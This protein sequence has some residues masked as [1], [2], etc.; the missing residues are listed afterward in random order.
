MAIIDEHGVVLRNIQEQ[1]Q[2][3]KCDIEELKQAGMG[4]EPV[5]G[6][7]GPAGEQGPV[8]PE[9][10]RGASL[11]GTSAMLPS[12][13][14]YKDGDMFLLNSGALYK[15][16]N[17]RWI[18]QA[19]LRGPQGVQGDPGSQV[20]PNPEGE[21]QDE[22]S[23]VE[24]DGVRYRIVGDPRWGSIGGVLTQ[25]ADLW[26]QL[27]NIREVAEGKS[28]GYL[29][30]INMAAPTTDEDF[31][32][33]HYCRG[34]GARITS[35][36]EF[37]S[38]VGASAYANDLFGEG[39]VNLPDSYI[40]VEKDNRLFVMVYDDE[41]APLKDGDIILTEQTDKADYW[42]WSSEDFFVLET[43][44]V[45]LSGF[46]KIDVDNNFS[47]GQTIPSLTM[48]AGAKINTVGVLNDITIWGSSVE[49]A[50][51]IFPKTNNLYDLGLSAN[52]WKDL[53]LS[54]IA[55]VPR[56]Q[57]P[58]KTAGRTKASYITTDNYD[59]IQAWINGENSITIY[60]GS[61]YVKKKTYVQNILEITSGNTLK[62]GDTTLNEAQLQALLALIA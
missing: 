46:A 44:K 50:K 58:I 23:N 57:F 25:Q 18:Q 20:I 19:T 51:T 55:F 41:Y 14:A 26:G 24:I 59:G 13:T 56:I 4:H 61:I 31:V 38:Y 9:G 43:T 5:P 36:T 17:G 52:R 48:P 45:D 37:D 34:D 15:K 47:V 40:I 11:Y 27:T 28:S 54:N 53:Y 35:L 39:N 33:R 12:P 16:V 32:N 10:E 42:Y 29:M 49:M 30:N 62:I 2:K 8:G 60:D 6:P 22:L 21:P 7:V 3:N 1:V